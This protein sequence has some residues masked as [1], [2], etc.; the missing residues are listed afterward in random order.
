[1]IGKYAKSQA[2]KRANRLPAEYRADRKAWM[3]STTLFDEW[4][5]KIDKRIKA[6]K[7]NVALILGNC[8]A[9]SV[10]TAAVRN[11][12]V[13]FLPPKTTSK[14]QPMDAGVI[15][16]LKVH[17]CSQ[18]VRQRLA[19]HE[20]G[21]SFQFDILDS[22]RLLRRA[23]LMVEPETINCYKS[24]GLHTGDRNEEQS[25]KKIQQ[26]FQVLA[27]TKMP[28]MHLRTV[29]PFPIGSTFMTTCLLMIMHQF[30]KCLVIVTLLLL[31]LTVP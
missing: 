15:K 30:Q 14:T 2:F 3:T 13:Y 5:I 16:N 28:G 31:C 21:V 23:W 17:Y 8:A 6:E 9:H 1:V 25:K 24:V 29:F 11:L 26:V 20:E 10:N 27:L 7:C 4:L 12:S 18:L 19:A 22:M